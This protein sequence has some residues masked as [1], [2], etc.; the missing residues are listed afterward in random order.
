M[1]VGFS[2]PTNAEAGSQAARASWKLADG[3][4]ASSR[5]LYFAPKLRAFHRV[6]YA[7]PRGLATSMMPPNRLLKVGV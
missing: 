7:I 1:Y 2:T 6:D 3:F 5:F 4:E